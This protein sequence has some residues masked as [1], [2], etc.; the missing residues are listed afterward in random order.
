MTQVVAELRSTAYKPRVAVLGSREQLC[1]H[2]K[3]AKLPRLA[4]NAACQNLNNKHACSYKSNLDGYQ[5]AVEGVGDA[6]S[7]I[8]DIEDLVKV[9]R[10]DNICPYYHSRDFSEYA[11]IIFLPYNYLLDTSIRSTLNVRWEQSVVV[12]DE[13]HNIEK[14]AS[15]A[16]SFSLTSTEIATCIRELQQVL[17]YIQAHKSEFESKAKEA[18]GSGNGAKGAGNGANGGLSFGMGSG[19]SDPPTLLG[20]TRVLRAMF[21]FERRVEQVPLTK[22]AVGDSTSCA[23]AGDWMLRTLI[24]CGFEFAMVSNH[25]IS[26]YHHHHDMTDHC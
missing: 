12:F 14:V 2:E 17:E 25:I 16:A 6:P 26:E 13:A 9:G 1:V 5:G 24:E 21:E 20:V 19:V 15:E 18:A 3:V 8:Y 7:P 23:L 4:V 22:G 11:D 10:R